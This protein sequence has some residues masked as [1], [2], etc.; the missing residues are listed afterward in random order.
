MKDSKDKIIP[1]DDLILVEEKEKGQIGQF[2]QEL[3]SD[4]DSFS[5]ES[6]EVLLKMKKGFKQDKKKFKDSWNKMIQKIKKVNPEY[7]HYKNLYNKLEEVH[8][9]TQE[10]KLKMSELTP[11]IEKLMEGQKDIE[12]YM[13]KNLGSDWKKIANSWKDCK[14]G[15]ISKGAFIKT[16]FSKIGKNFI[17]IFL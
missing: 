12:K 3:K 9:D 13:K 5:V 7:R 4:I 10:I 6:G 14:N 16:A 15:E 11:M 2:F 17:S 1:Q 8:D